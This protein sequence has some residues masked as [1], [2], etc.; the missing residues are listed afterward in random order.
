M[1]KIFLFIVTLVF[2]INLTFAQ[3]PQSFKYQ[4][5]VRD[6]S[7]IVIENQNVGIMIDILNS[8]GVT[9]YSEEHFA[10]TNQFGLINIEIGGGT[11][12]SGD[13]T[14]I[15]WG[16]DS[17]FVQIE[18]DETGGGTYQLMGTS[19]LLSVP[20]AIYANKSGNIN[21]NDTSAINELQL[22]NLSNDTLYLSNG[23][24]VVLPDNV[25]D[26]DSDPT[27]EFQI[28]SFSSNTLDLSN[29]NSVYIPDN[30]NDADSDPTNELQVL[31]FSND[32][33]YLSNGNNIYLTNLSDTSYWEKNGND[34][35]YNLG[36]VGIGAVTPNSKLLVQSD[37]IAGINDDIFSVLNANGDTVFAVYQEGVRI[38]VDDDGGTKA[39]GS[40]GGFAV[41][42]F[43]PTKA[44][45]TNEYFRVT[46]DSVRVYIDDDFVSA[47][48]TGSRGGFAVGG[49]NPT[50]GT[51][52]DNYLFVQ[53]DSTRIWTNGNAGFEIRD[54]ATGSSNYLDLTPSNYFIG[55][56]SGISNNN[57]LYNCL[58]GYQAG[59][60]NY[61]GDNNVFI[62]YQTGMVND[63]GDNNIF[64]GSQSGFNNESGS[65]NVGIGTEALFQNIS[66]TDNTAVGYN[67]LYNNVNGMSNTAIGNTSLYYNNSGWSNVACGEQALYMNTSGGSNVSIGTWAL[68]SNTTGSNNTAVGNLAFFMG[69]GHTNST[70]LGYQA[71][72]SASNKVRIG[73]TTVTVIEG[74]APY[75]FPSDGRFKNNVTEEVKGLDFI[76]RL[77]PIEYNFDTRKFDAF[78]MKNMPDSIKESIMSKNDY[79]LSSNI[80]Q[81]GFIAQEVV[82]AAKESGYNFN[83]VHIPVNDDD[84]YNIAY[85]LFTVPLVKAVQEQ[86]EVIENQKSKIEKIEKE[87]AEF[88]QQMQSLLQRIEI[89]EN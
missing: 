32:T 55:H 60:A 69:S 24:Y 1:K 70:A 49:F 34:I 12:Y 81:S 51:L 72:I 39:N 14:T 56:E 58:F 86:Q 46:P 63:Y 62:G 53:D 19:Q 50:K 16:T 33:L 87:N 68:Y 61:D 71:A 21:N 23:N 2:G 76:I 28:L 79:S 64:I 57:G 25:N 20:Y 77:R 26:A 40:R 75:S 42:G 17:Y 84:N 45:F 83:G 11:V 13:F 18:L 5:V 3:S 82:E 31:N 74:Q 7:G 36:N 54:L 9:V 10:T 48:A 65:D 37:A 89:L 52:S 30:I 15:N 8:G 4:A 47:K 6:A 80:R 41:G 88:K 38:W 22:L 29:G 66:G 67:T 73:N 27:N 35:Y 78:L 43:S 59:M 85:S 44:G